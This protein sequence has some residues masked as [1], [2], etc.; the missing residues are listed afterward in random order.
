MA[1][2]RL[3]NLLLTAACALC[4]PFQGELSAYLEEL[5][6]EEACTDYLRLTYFP[7]A[8]VE[9]VLRRYSIPHEERYAIYRDLVAREPDIIAIVEE[10][11]ARVNK[12]L[13]LSAA[14]AIYRQT[15]YQVFAEVLKINGISRREQADAILDEI[16]FKKGRLYKLCME[17]KNEK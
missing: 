6:K 3:K 5:G 16:Q 2:S 11:A 15:L 7:H 1:A 10:R 17:N 12:E 4:T 9:D 14:V 13:K 8:V